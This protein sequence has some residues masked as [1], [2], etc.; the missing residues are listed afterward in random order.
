[1]IIEKQSMDSSCVQM[2]INT[3]NCDK[4]NDIGIR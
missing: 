2:Y 3:N 1:M 4:L